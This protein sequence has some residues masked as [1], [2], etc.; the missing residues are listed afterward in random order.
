M[1]TGDAPCQAGPPPTVAVGGASPL[2]PWLAYLSAASYFELL[3]HAD[4]RS[5]VRFA[6][7]GASQGPGV[8][9]KVSRLHA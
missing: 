4:A 3:A 2:I 8:Q 6:Q 1:P 5:S 9:V 7:S